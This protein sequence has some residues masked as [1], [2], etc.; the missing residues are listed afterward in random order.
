MKKQILCPVINRGS[1]AQMAEL[2]YQLLIE[3]QVLQ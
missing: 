3:Y 2:E 1:E